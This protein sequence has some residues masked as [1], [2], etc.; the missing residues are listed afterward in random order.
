[1]FSLIKK[2]QT[3]NEIEKLIRDAQAE[4]DFSK[5]IPINESILK[6]MNIDQ[7]LRILNLTWARGRA[8]AECS[9]A[10]LIINELVSREIIDQTKAFKVDYSITGEKLEKPSY[11]PFDPGLLVD[12]CLLIKD[13]DECAKLITKL[14]ESGIGVRDNKFLFNILKTSPNITRSLMSCDNFL[15]E[16]LPFNVKNHKDTFINIHKLQAEVIEWAVKMESRSIFDDYYAEMDAAEQR[17]ERIKLLFEL[18][19]KNHSE[20]LL[21]LE[22]AINNQAIALAELIVHKLLI[23]NKKNEL[24][25]FIKTNFS[26][27]YDKCN[28][29]NSARLIITLSRLEVAPWSSN[30]NL[31]YNGWENIL[32]YHLK[33]ADL[34]I[35]LSDE[36]IIPNTILIEYIRRSITCPPTNFQKLIE[37]ANK[38]NI[39]AEPFEYYNSAGEAKTGSLLDVVLCRI[40][41]TDPGSDSVLLD[42]KEIAQYLHN[43]ELNYS[44]ENEEILRK[45]MRQTTKNARKT[46]I[47]SEDYFEE[48]KP[49]IIE[50]PVAQN[51]GVNPILHENTNNLISELDKC[52]LHNNFDK[53]V[54]VLCEIRSINKDSPSK[55]E[56]LKK[57]LVA[58]IACNAEARSPKR[59]EQ[60]KLLVAA[61]ADK[62]M[63]DEKG[64]NLVGIAI[65]CKKRNLARALINE[66]VDLSKGNDVYNLVKNKNNTL[67]EFIQEKRSQIQ[68]NVSSNS[69]LADNTSKSVQKKR[70]QIQLNVSSTPELAA[71]TSN[72]IVLLSTTRRQPVTRRSRDPKPKDQNPKD[73]ISRKF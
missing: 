66:D 53:L 56:L 1:M 14:H 58:V 24:S 67:A 48:K 73:N 26:K 12:L 30:T 59:L 60:I 47:D 49:L 3:Q 61:G 5:R 36:R 71:E 65:L 63:V 70:P 40:S 11:S 15:N 64:N 55:P 37:Q 32:L 42:L 4:K 44:E 39:L 20:L 35:K 13:P 54:E 19:N 23:D 69:E 18:K 43:C 72:Q 28:S 17:K 52:V 46:I 7:L 27:I 50:C 45:I 51:G 22:D 31:D 57:A 38:L 25:E 29:D 2:I 9:Q 34:V 10:L 33:D 8:R 68:L 62:N 16:V 21:D 6:K 41:N